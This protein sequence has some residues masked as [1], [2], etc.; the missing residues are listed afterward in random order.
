MTAD[1]IAKLEAYLKTTLNADIVVKA[2]PKAKDSAEIYL[3]Q[4]FLAVVYKDE[5]EGEVAFQVNM[6]I[7]PEDL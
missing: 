3:G 7:L 4:E 6:T 1:D 2:R 5:D